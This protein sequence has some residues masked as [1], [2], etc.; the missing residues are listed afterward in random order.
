MVLAVD[1]AC[2]YSAHI[3]YMRDTAQS[4]FKLFGIHGIK[5]GTAEQRPSVTS[6]GL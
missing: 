5:K 1:F 6:L 2:C 4:T 3:G